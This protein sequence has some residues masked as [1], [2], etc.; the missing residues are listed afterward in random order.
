M[1]SIAVLAS[2]SGT[3]LQ[4]IIDA[5]EAGSIDG[6]VDLVISDKADAYAITRAKKHGIETGLVEKK[7]GEKREAYDE[8]LIE[9]LKAHDIELVVLAGFMR[10]LS[11][12]FLRA[13]PMRVLNIHP[14]LLPSFPGL[15]VHRRAIEA[16][17]R[18][19]GCT[20]HFVDEGVD[21]GPIIIQA[22]VPILEDDNPKI[23]ADRILEEEHRIYPEA[24]RLYCEGRLTVKGGRV[25][26][27]DALRTTGVLENPPVRGVKDR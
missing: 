4:S 23:L 14:S 2:G 8:R 10:I 24:V 13:F 17:A 16:G 6:K 20:V 12:L 9:V 18:F 26:V 19:S 15:D 7:N 5:L 3:N 22:V 25:T 21:T 11:P 27:K 1:V